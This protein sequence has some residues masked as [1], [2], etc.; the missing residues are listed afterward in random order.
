M[1]NIIK[2][3]FN[4]EKSSAEE[5]KRKIHISA[6]AL[7][8]DMAKADTDYSDDEKEKI[9]LIL[10]EVFQEDDKY[11]D[12]LIIDSE[13]ELKKSISIYEFASV[14]NKNFTQDEKYTLIKNLWKIIFSDDTVDI[15]EEHLVKQIAGTLNLDRQDIIAAKFEVKKELQERSD[16]NS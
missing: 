13:G 3:L 12:Q 16:Q 7:Y 9:R 5:E 10:K 14:L 2:K 15:Y 1:L 6:A 4:P 8:I 11:I